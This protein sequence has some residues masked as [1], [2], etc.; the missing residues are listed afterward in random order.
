MKFYVVALFAFLAVATAT[1]T[2]MTFMNTLKAD[3]T[4]LME[5]GAT[6]QSVLKLLDDILKHEEKDLKDLI[7]K[8]EKVDQPRFLATIAKA[9][10][11]VDDKKEE[12]ATIKK[13][14]ES[15]EQEVKQYEENI[16][17]AEVKIA[18]NLKSVTKREASRCKNNIVFLD[19]VREARHVKQFLV[20]LVKHMSSKS[21]A[22]TIATNAAAFLSLRDVALNKHEDSIAELTKIHLMSRFFEEEAHPKKGYTDD[23]MDKMFN[24]HG[25]TKK[26]IGDDQVD[27]KKGALKLDT[28]HYTKESAAD[29][30][31][32]V[33][34]FIKSIISEIDSNIKKLRE[35]EETAVHEFQQFRTKIE[36][37]NLSLHIYI[38]QCKEFIVQLK[39]DIEANKVVYAKCLSEIPPLVAILKAHEKSYK[40]AYDHY[41]A[42]R[43]NLEITVIPTLKEAKKKYI[44]HVEKTA[45]KKYA[46]RIS[47]YAA[48]NKFDKTNK[49]F[50]SRTH[51][52]YKKATVKL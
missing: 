6:V 7:H 26:E 50:D 24:V 47:D 31:N 43:A 51:F 23:E 32:G 14:I 45:G 20:Y 44:A 9:Q 39:K 30:V 36:Y 22:N 42:R 21:F 1:E 12:C 25:R 15:Q 35:A 37:E 46:A 18:A 10:K 28:Y 41:V 13:F 4:E 27:N 5:K 2:E 48:D 16:H 11:A 49:A 3:I 33:I 8:W 19:K 52:A 17:R 38:K 34:T 40:D 29:Y